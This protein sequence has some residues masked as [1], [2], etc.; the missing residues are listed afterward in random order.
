MLTN[1]K[2]ILNKC[3]VCDKTIN[4]IREHLID[5]YLCKQCQTT[6]QICDAPVMYPLVNGFGIP[7]DKKHL[8][9]KYCYQG[10]FDNKTCGSSYKIFDT[11][12]HKQTCCLC[13]RKFIPEHISWEYGLK[14]YATYLVATG[15]PICDKCFVCAPKSDYCWECRKRY[16][17]RNQLFRHLEETNHYCDK[18]INTHIKNSR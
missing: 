8:L 16:P 9:C 13:H 7:I 15:K 18:K 17:S 14:Y 4:F 3:C 11:D 6:C 2:N 5:E 1:D 10:C 12:D